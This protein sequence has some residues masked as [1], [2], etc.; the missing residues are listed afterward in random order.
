MV[1]GAASLMTLFYGLKAAGMWSDTRGANILDGGAPWYGTFECRDGGHVAIGSIE[2]KFYADLVRV[3]GL[4]PATLPKQHDRRHWPSLHAAFAASF[5]T[6][7]RDEWCALMEGTDICFAPVLG[8]DEAPRHAHMTARETFVAPSGVAQPAPA[9]RFSRTPG[10][11]AG[12]PPRRGEGGDAVLADWG[13]GQ[14]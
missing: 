4:D 7:T 13:I 6:K 3:L 8:L 2:G 5:R 10:A 9:P 1:D 11:I 14:D 12:R